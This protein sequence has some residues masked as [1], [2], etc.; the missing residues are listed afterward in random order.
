MSF[1][2]DYHDCCSIKSS[3]FSPSIFLLVLRD[4]SSLLMIIWFVERKMR[5]SIVNRSKVKQKSDI[6]FFWLRIDRLF[7]RRKRLMFDAT[8]R[9]YSRRINHRW[10][11]D[12]KCWETKPYGRRDSLLERKSK[13]EKKRFTSRNIFRTQCRF[14]EPMNVFRRIN[15]HILACNRRL[16]TRNF[17]PNQTFPHA[18]EPTFA[19]LSESYFT[20]RSAF[21]RPNFHVEIFVSRTFNREPNLFQF[22]L[23]NIFYHRINDDSFN[24]RST[25][26]LA[27]STWNA[28]RNFVV[29]SFPMKSTL[30]IIPR[31]CS[32]LFSLSFS[33]SSF[34][35]F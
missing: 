21:Q 6:N 33:D 20:R 2:R 32:R 35:N 7:Q 15:F 13:T 34:T 24:L 28:W 18:I 26:L 22:S 4:F 25:N 17:F 5:R 19:S 1:R 8:Q 10:S 12:S 23:N 3:S 16:S 14:N 30:T 31:S 29:S 27:E 9:A 11:T